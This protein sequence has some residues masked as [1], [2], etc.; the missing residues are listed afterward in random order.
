[1]LFG[2]SES[3]TLT[4]TYHYTNFNNKSAQ[5]LYIKIDLEVQPVEFMTAKSR[6][7]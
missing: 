2:A 6:K 7:C 4:F 5:K 1:M 3:R